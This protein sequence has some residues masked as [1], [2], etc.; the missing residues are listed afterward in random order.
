MH[1]IKAT[2]LA[3]LACAISFGQG[4]QMHYLSTG[5]TLPVWSKITVA[6]SG[7]NF[8]VTCSPATTLCGTSPV[9]K[10]AALT[11]SVTLLTLPAKGYI[12][13]CMAK[14]GTSFAGTTTLTA[15][16]GITGTLTAC[17][18]GAYDLNAAVSNTNLSVALPATPIVS[19]A[20][21]SVILA[22][23]GTI[24]NLSSISAGSTDVWILWSVLP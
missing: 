12:L 20:G 9:A 6:N 11:Q 7:A 8:T 22:L 15:T 14:S 4:S 24:S 21:T 10:A 2:L 5:N 23:T 17:I 19:I 16:V 13:S 3:V 18:S 1:T